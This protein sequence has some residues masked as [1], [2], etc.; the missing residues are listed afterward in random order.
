MK[1]IIIHMLFVSSKPLEI[2]VQDSD[3]IVSFVPLAIFKD[4]LDSKLIS[5]DG[6]TVIRPVKE[7]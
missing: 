5:E 2:E 7:I 3:Q 6:S 4:Y 1:G